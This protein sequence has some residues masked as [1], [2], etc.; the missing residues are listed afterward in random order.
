MSSNPETWYLSICL[1][2]LWFLS[3][4]CIKFLEYTSFASLGRFIPSYFI[5]FDAMIN[6]I[7]PLISYSGLLVLVYRNAT[8]FCV[9]ILYSAML[10]NSLMSSDSF[11]VASLGFSIYNIM[12]SA[13]S[14]SFTSFPIWIPF[15]SFPSDYSG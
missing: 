12:L 14:D 8:D 1:C 11:L 7:V 10:P 9:L 13:N 2:Y 6:R 4:A 15:H 5:P 3:S